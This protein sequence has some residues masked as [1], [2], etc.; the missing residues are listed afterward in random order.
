MSR[1]DELF[2]TVDKWYS[3][4]DYQAFRISL[5]V[6]RSHFL[7][8]RKPIWLFMVAPPGS[9]KTS[10]M[11]QALSGLPRSIVIGNLTAN[12]FLSGVAGKQQVGILERLGKQTEVINDFGHVDLVSHGDAIFLF[13]DFTTVLSWPSDKRMDIVA[14]LREIADGSYSKHHGGGD[15]KLW[16]GHI[17]ALAAVTPDLD[18]FYAMFSSLGERFM[19]VRWNRPGMDAGEKAAAQQGHEIEIKSALQNQ[20]RDL[21]LDVIG[22]DKVKLESPVATL[23]QIHRT[24]QMAEIIAWARTRCRWEGQGDNK[25]IVD[26][27]QPEANTRLTDGF[28]AVQKGIASL[29]HRDCL[30][31][32]DYHD[33]VRLAFD[34]LIPAKRMI[35]QNARSQVQDKIPHTILH[36]NTKRQ[37][38]QELVALGL[39]KDAAEPYE[40]TEW[41]TELHDNAEI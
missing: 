41:A 13:K 35:L 9:G 21:F 32:D 14:Q 22:E 15:P 31:D 17:T 39:L 10:I 33:G 5:G 27:P 40:L 20:A 16:K 29:E 23:E 25:T 30:T 19:A 4:P 6:V 18:R 12:T 8:L 11:V 34:C 7:P 28:L 1:L 2:A 36:M 3:D 26:V 37:K 24:A 38:A